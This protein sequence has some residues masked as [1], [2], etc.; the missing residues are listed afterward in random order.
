MKIG[1]IE[2]FLVKLPYTTGGDGNIGNMDWS[3][4]DYVLI[5][6]ETEQGL[7]GWGDAFAYG[8]SAQ[9]VKAVVDNMLAPSLIGKDAAAVGQLSYLLQQGNHLLGRYGITMFAISGIDIALWDLAGK[10]AGV[11]LSTLLGGARRGEIPAYA[12]LFNYSDP[13]R[14]AEHCQRALGEGYKSIKLHETGEPEV[15]AARIAMGDGVP[16]MVDTNCPWTPWQAR[17]KALAF[18]PY[19]LH[20]L[21][22]PIFPPEDFDSLARLGIEVDIPLAAGENACTAFEF[23]KMIE[24]EAVTY[25]QPSVT[26]VGGITEFR[27]I[28]ALAEVQGVT[29]MPHAP[30]FAPGLLATL[31]L[32]STMPDEC[33][34]ETFYYKTLEAS[35]YGDAIVAK[36][37]NITVPTGPGLGLEPDMDVIRDY[38]AK[39]G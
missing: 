11:P 10:A 5:R 24:A 12:S 23:Q 26:K 36:D 39:D 27:K 25:I 22:E 4:L 7:V 29:V 6:I 32:L 19:D 15:R 30:Y 9:S 3:T 38:A 20:W 35:L 28:I 2:T 31:H 21:E 18:K 37:G 16:L 33:L 34:A 1:K 17:E 13:D 14:V 8:A